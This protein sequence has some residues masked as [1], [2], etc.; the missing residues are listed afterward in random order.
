MAQS[1]ALTDLSERIRSKAALRDSEA[2]HRAILDATID[3]IITI[4]ARG[5][6][7]SANPAAERLCGY[8]QADVPFYGQARYGQQ[9]TQEVVRCLSEYLQ[10]ARTFE[11]VPAKTGCRRLSVVSVVSDP[12]KRCP[13][14]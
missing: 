10:S 8:T 7:E 11:P 12:D 1:T 3:G 6:I 9:S 13:I 4:N 2:R 14:H 5:M